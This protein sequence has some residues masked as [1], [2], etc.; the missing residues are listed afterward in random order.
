MSMAINRH[1]V[2]AGPPRLVVSRISPR[3][4]F[5]VERKGRSRQPLSSSVY[6]YRAATPRFT[7]VRKMVLLK[8]AT[9]RLSLEFLLGSKIATQGAIKKT[10]LIGGSF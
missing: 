6:F 10:R 5:P 4:P 3:L 1:R 7:Q 8:I 9:S 2:V